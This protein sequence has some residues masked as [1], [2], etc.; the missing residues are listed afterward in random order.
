MTG[1]IMLDLD[2]LTLPQIVDCVLDS[3]IASKQ[4]E[5]EH[6]EKVCEVLLSRHRHQ[7]TQNEKKGLPLI[8][9]LAEIG[10]KTSDR[11]IEGKDSS[12]HL[13]PGKGSVKGMSN[14]DVTDGNGEL[15]ETPSQH[16]FNEH[17]A[18]KIPAGAEASNILVGEV[19]FLTH[20]VLAFVRLNK[21]SLLGDL[22]EVPVP[23]RFIFILLGPSGNQQR[24][25]EIGRSIAT[26]MSDEV[27]HDV[28][29]HAKNRGDLLA[30]I[31]EF[32]D[33][34]I[35]LPPGE[36]DPTIRIEPPKSIPSQEGRKQITAADGSTIPN[37]Q[38]SG[39]PTE[40]CANND[41]A[42]IRT[43]RIFGGLVLD[44]KRRAP[45]YLSDFKD[46]LDVQCIAAF[47]FMFFACLTPIITFG[48]LLGSATHDNMAAMES[49]LAGA[50]CGITYHIFSGQPLT[51][52]GSTG[53]VLVFE[54][55]VYHFSEDFGLDYLGLRFWIGL[56]ISL[57]LL[58]MVA[59]DLSAL[60][61]YITR[62][63]EESFAALIALIFIVESFKKLFH[64]LDHDGVNLDPGSPLDYTCHCH[65]PNATTDEDGFAI[66]TTLAVNA[67][68]VN[69]TA[70]GHDP[71]GCE[72]AGG[73][74]YGAGCDTPH[75]TPDVFFFSCMIFLGTF[76]M[77][78]SLKHFKTAPYFPTK[79]RSII[80]DFAVML[81]IVCMVGVDALVGLG[82]PKLTVPAEFRPT[83][84]DR[85]WVVNPFK[86][87][88]WTIPAA[89]APALLATILIF[90]DQQ[91]TAV[92][93]NRKENKLKKGCGYHLDLF[94]I[95]I[96]IGVCSVLGIPWFVAATVLSIN[97]V[98]SLRLESES[99]AP[100]EKPKFLGV[101]E[102][103]VTGIL[104]FLMVGLSVL[105]T[106]VLVLI[107]MPVLYGVFLFM[108]ISS[109]AGVQLIQR[110]LII[111]MPA[112]YQ[113]DYI[114]LRNVPVRRVHLF[115]AIQAMCLACLW[116]IKTIKSIS[117]IFPIMVLAM[118]FVRKGLDWVFTRHELEWLDDILP[119]THKREKEDE[120]QAL[121]SDFQPSAGGLIE[122]TGGAVNIPLKD[123]K[124][125]KVPVDRLVYDPETKEVNI[126]D[127]MSK[128][129]IWK[130]LVANESNPNIQDSPSKDGLRNRKDKKEKDEKKKKE[131]VKFSISEEDEET[132]ALMPEIVV[133][134]PSKAATPDDDS[135]V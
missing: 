90:M 15:P 41:N 17:F 96:Q 48:G 83:R 54:T 33:Q 3:M 68:P 98:N 100:G 24:Y 119:E 21:A 25:H 111:L 53:P 9:S 47:F 89:L 120:K 37:G 27:F 117:I 82:T 108:G 57:I 129:A 122:M 73:Y 51:I 107:P 97:H 99:S 30:G 12:G 60:V 103:R 35:V 132:Q 29:Y 125:I 115:T 66:T 55:I 59:F 87:P 104:V 28:A 130:Q 124:S 23:T 65:P 1:T 49:L 105:M 67:T 42:L 135:K 20:P 121:E 131:P 69:Y 32:L 26:L 19:E 8:R 7:H 134:P 40:I 43:G 75:Y 2:A 95:A 16:K 34:V 127:E 56:W 76:T 18:K 78:Y 94:I 123:G 109:L 38:P 110:M 80:S 6:R 22:T 74:L 58:V 128:T 70:L 5:E 102:Q 13:T 62:F 79:V 45:F 126:S 86:N 77:A 101:R 14:K 4:L 72:L 11:K 81:A 116:V 106:P 61:R 93:V 114:F 52:I 133:D 44:V 112:K 39:Q 46:A 92:I 88:L 84:A 71:A 91:I 31:D 64:I 36:W 10:R 85:G 118:C 50:I 113:P 63:T